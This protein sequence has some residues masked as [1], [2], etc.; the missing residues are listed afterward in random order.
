[1]RII[2]IL[3]CLFYHYAVVNSDIFYINRHNCCLKPLA[4]SINTNTPVQKVPMTSPNA[5]GIMVHNCLTGASVNTGDTL[6]CVTLRTTVSDGDKISPRSVTK[7]TGRTG[8]P[9][10]LS[11]NTE[12][13]SSSPNKLSSPT[14][15]APQSQ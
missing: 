15:A 1:M 5:P 11:T 12:C 10:A 8:L 14:G 2:R 7:A 6:H 3:N 9:V 13:G 4:V